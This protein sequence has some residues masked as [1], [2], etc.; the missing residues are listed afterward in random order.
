MRRLLLV[1]LLAWPLA[2]AAQA[3]SPPAAVPGAE[4]MAPHRALYRLVLDPGRNAAGLQAAEGLLL[5]E[6]EDACEGW[7]TRQRFRLIVE[8]QDGNRVETVSEHATFE[9][10]D[11]SAL[12]FSLTQVTE[13][14]VTQRIRGEAVMG[15]DGGRVVFQDPVPTERRLAPGTLFPMLHTIRA[16]AAARQGQRILVAPLL[17]GTDADGPQ[18]TTTLILSPWLP[19]QPHPRHP[20][21]SALPSARMR[22]A[23]FEAGQAGAA[24]T[25]SYEVSLRYWANGVAD[26]VTM[27]FGDFRLNGALLELQPLPGGC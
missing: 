17:D 21:L 16:L 12:R 20:A 8:D 5:F 19:P 15:P 9:A 3:S 14:A 10:K 24:A 6:V 25:P 4:E 23:F 13:G 2:A 26:E 11:G 27:D 18:D 22:I 7:A 1:V